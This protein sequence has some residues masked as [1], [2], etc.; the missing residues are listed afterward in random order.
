M[1][2]SPMEKTLGMRMRPCPVCILQRDDTFCRPVVGM[3]DTYIPMFP[4]A[5]AKQQKKKELTDFVWSVSS[6]FAISKP[7]GIILKDPKK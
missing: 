4:L 3:P 6:L 1:M 5:S 2:F 7:A